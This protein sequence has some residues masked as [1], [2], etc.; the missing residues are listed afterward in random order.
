MD[1]QHR[2][3]I[4]QR[5]DRISQLLYRASLREKEG[6][7]IFKELY[8]LLSCTLS[9]LDNNSPFVDR[10]LQVHLPHPCNPARC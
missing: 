6:V 7:S 8:G 9:A 1:V 5:W 4:T 2:W 3:V 10:L